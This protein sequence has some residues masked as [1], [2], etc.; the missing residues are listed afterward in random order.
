MIIGK[1]EVK[2]Y[3]LESGIGFGRSRSEEQPIITLESRVVSRVHGEFLIDGEKAIIRDLGSSNGT[4]VNGV[5]YGTGADLQEKQLEDGDV[6][7]IDVRSQE[8]MHEDAVL[9]IYRYTEVCDVN[10]AS[11]E[12]R[13]DANEFCVGRNE[14]NSDIYIRDSRVSRRHAVFY[15]AVNGWAIKDCDSSNGV[16][17][18]NQRLEQPKYLKRMDCVR[19]LDTLFVYQAN[20]LLI[21]MQPDTVFIRPFISEEEQQSRG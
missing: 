3:V 17:L 21:G 14:Q 4:T 8:T 5:Y 10:W 18:N 6:I 1:K 13:E 7:R 9:M 15:R 19:I 11:L 16:F 20:Q 2:E 12:L